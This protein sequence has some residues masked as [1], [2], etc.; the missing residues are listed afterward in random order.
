[1]YNYR[2]I[3]VVSSSN[4]F[5]HC[6]G[7]E[8]VLRIIDVLTEGETWVTWTGSIGW[9]SGSDVVLGGLREGQNERQNKK[10]K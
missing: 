3:Y 9:L 8:I 5:E 10:E 2:V 7:L 6:I 4:K 1:M